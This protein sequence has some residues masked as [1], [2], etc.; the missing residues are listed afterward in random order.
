[1]TA[2]EKF[3]EKKARNNSTIW[4]SVLTGN[5]RINA[6]ASEYGVKTATFRKQA[7]AEGFKTVMWGDEI[8]I[9]R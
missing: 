6:D 7:N 8:Q 1:M 5:C 9:Y 4:M 3:M 2:I